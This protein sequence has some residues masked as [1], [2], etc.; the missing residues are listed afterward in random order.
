MG[1][2]LGQQTMFRNYT[3]E[4][5]LGQSQVEAVIQDSIG[6]LWIGTHHGV[7]RFDG[8]TFKNFTVRD[9]LAGNIITAAYMDSRGRLYFGHPT[10]SI[11]TQEGERFATSAAP[12]ERRGMAIQDFLED[13]RDTLWIAT[14]GAGVLRLGA[15]EQ[16]TEPVAVPGSPA[17]ARALASFGG[18]VWVAAA[19]G[20]YR[21]DPTLDA[22]RFESLNVPQ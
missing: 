22:P 15:R 19:D 16:E 8:H 1:P 17:Q 7:S 20:L 21:F 10:G 14:E 4:H 9:G 5:G 2:V 11:T 6:Y 13:E 12:Q 18:S 3:V